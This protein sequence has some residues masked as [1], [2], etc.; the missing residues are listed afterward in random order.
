M[1]IIVHEDKQ[2]RIRAVVPVDIR[3]ISSELEKVAVR[4]LRRPGSD[5]RRKPRHDDI[6]SKLK[7]REIVWKRIFIRI[8]RNTPA[9]KS[10]PQ[11][12]L[13]EVEVVYPGKRA[14]TIQTKTIE[15]KIS[16][17]TPPRLSSFEDIKVLFL[18]LKHQALE[19]SLK[20]R[21]FMGVMALLI[22]ISCYSL[23][24]HHHT[25]TP[26]PVAVKNLGHHAP[27]LPKGTPN[28]ATVLPVGKTIQQLGGGV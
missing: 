16:L 5:I 15:I 26:P 14:K 21:I 23:V 27:A 12:E 4:L 1:K 3:D 19:G 25:Y 17:P 8:L 20:V 18:Q 7:N 10:L 13:E 11:P 24:R 28:Y 9:A 6:Q 22:S 2:I